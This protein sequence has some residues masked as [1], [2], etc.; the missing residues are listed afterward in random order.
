MNYT[1][2]NNG[3]VVA[4]YLTNRSCTLNQMMIPGIDATTTYEAIEFHIHSASEHSI[5]GQYF[6]A[7]LHIVHKEIDGDRLAVVGIFL[8]PGFPSN[9]P[10]F[11]IALDH[12]NAT[13]TK[14]ADAC[15]KKDNSARR[16]LQVNQ[17]FNV[18]DLIPPNSSYYQYN[19]SLITTTTSPCSDVDWN[20]AS[21]K[22]MISVK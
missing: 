13:R 9:N 16:Q 11:Q 6:G 1:I 15:N 12:W 10:T 5:N 14:A 18:Y 2:S 7:E 3:L 17:Y 21:K 20:I 8:K 19:G 4:T 22:Q